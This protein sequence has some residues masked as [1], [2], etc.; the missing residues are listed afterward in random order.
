M[1][2]LYFCIFNALIRLK[3]CIKYANNQEN[4]TVIPRITHN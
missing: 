1:Q 2:M 3:K 4:C